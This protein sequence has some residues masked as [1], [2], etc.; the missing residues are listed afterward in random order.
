MENVEPVALDQN[1]W[2]FKMP[3]HRWYLLRPALCHLMPGGLT[4]DNSIKLKE[5]FKRFKDYVVDPKKSRR[6]PIIPEEYSAGLETHR[7]H[8]MRFIMADNLLI[9]IHAEPDALQ[10]LFPDKNQTYW[11][12]MSEKL[13]PY[14]A[15]LTCSTC[16]SEVSLETR[17]CALHELDL[18]VRKDEV[19]LCIECFEN[20]YSPL[21]TCDMHKDEPEEEEQEEDESSSEWSLDALLDTTQRERL[22]T[23][24]LEQALHLVKREADKLE[25]ILKK[26]R[27]K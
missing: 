1:L 9:F 21:I 7:P 17:T 3:D 15:P 8:L 24:I 26:R 23:L 10:S 11:D 22:K 6:W 14:L 16:A 19:Y 5:R 27:K 13:L 12:A 20:H 25:H 2:L 4:K 18:D